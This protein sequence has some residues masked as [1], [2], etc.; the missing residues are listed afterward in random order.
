MK[1]IKLDM[2]K[3]Y[4]PICVILMKREEDEVICPECGYTSP[5][6][7]V[8]HRKVHDKLAL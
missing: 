4:C 1:I 3:V 2:Y 5:I 8:R 6:I 7:R